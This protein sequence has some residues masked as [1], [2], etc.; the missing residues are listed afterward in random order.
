MRLRNEHNRLRRTEAALKSLEAL[1]TKALAVLN[2][3]DCQ[4]AL[5]KTPG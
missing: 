3:F 2:K 5:L 4:F 1:F